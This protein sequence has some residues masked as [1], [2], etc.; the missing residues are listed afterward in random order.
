MAEL[1]KEELSFLLYLRTDQHVHFLASSQQDSLE[2][3]LRVEC[4]WKWGKQHKMVGL[5]RPESCFASRADLP[6]LAGRRISAASVTRSCQTGDKC[7][8]PELTPS[9][10]STPL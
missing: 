10:R 7:W 8:V 2:K 9:L 4:S 3:V 6:Y 5:V 1:R